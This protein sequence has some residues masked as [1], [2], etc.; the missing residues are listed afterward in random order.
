MMDIPFS[1]AC[2]RNKTPILSAIEQ[3]LDT[4][5]TVLEVGTGTAQHAVHFCSM[6]PHL[7]WQTSDCSHYLD[8]IKAQLHAA[9]LSNIAA[10]VELD[11]NQKK[12][13]NSSNT[14]D[15]LYTANT[16]HIMNQ[17]SV[18]AFFSGLTQVM[19]PQSK[20]IIY[21]PFKYNGEFTSASNADFDNSLR[22]RGVGSGI[23]DIEWINEL[24]MSQN[25]SLLEDHS[26]P[27]NNQCLVFDK[28]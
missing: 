24:A 19:T 26:M 8:G 2:E 10:P 25:Y 14:F 11:V 12:W 1:D 20:V 28:I 17:D 15:I 4:A 22:L 5:K 6:K 13:L 16:L 23:R 18:R 7:F 9:Q 3:H 21:G 27:A